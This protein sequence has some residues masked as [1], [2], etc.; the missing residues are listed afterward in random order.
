M[1]THASTKAPYYIEGEKPPN[2][3]RKITETAKMAPT[4]KEAEKRK[5]VR[6]TFG[7]W[8]DCCGSGTGS[9]PRKGPGLNN[10]RS[11]TSIGISMFPN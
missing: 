3:T 2:L 4:Y 8:R 11:R 1:P 7:F 10:R 5:N 6:E 9:P